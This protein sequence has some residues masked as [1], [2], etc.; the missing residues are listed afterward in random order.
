MSRRTIA[1]LFAGVLFVVILAVGTAL[2]IA[3]ESGSD[4]GAAVTNVTTSGADA[5]EGMTTTTTATDAKGD[6]TVT[7]VESSGT[8][9][10]GETVTTT[11]TKGSPSLVERLLGTEVLALGFAL[12]IA[13]LLAAVIQRVVM[14][15]YGF[16]FAGLEVS[17]LIDESAS[18]LDE[19]KG[20][21]ATLDA[22]VKSQK[23]E[24]D[25]R[26]KVDVERLDT[27]LLL[28]ANLLERVKALEL[29]H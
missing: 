12:L 21:I 5:V 2:V 27:L 4:P 20:S 25:K 22:L 16:K 17:N 1:D 13:V 8:P 14:G 24:D 9:P 19:V 26:H 3:D 29:K 11:E 28:S 15:Q 23:E 10:T 18:A 7:T 6:E